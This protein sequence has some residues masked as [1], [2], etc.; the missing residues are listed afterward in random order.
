MGEKLSPERLEF[1][2]RDY[3][4]G[5]IADV[6]YRVLRYEPGRL[7]SG[8]TILDRHRQQDHYIHAG[9]LAAMADHTAGYAAFSL[10]AEDRRILTI[11]F[12]INFLRPAYGQGLICRSRILRAGGQV[13]TGESEVFD[14]R[15]AGEV[16]AA[17]ALVTLMSVHR[18]RIKPLPGF[19]DN[20]TDRSD[21]TD[22]SD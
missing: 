15:S 12:K 6:G 21:P 3:A 2:T 7:E 20:P 11:E 18:S 1:L 4:R 14:Q 17:K 22:P 8:L 13:L 9:V 5:F 16:L 10:V 19:L